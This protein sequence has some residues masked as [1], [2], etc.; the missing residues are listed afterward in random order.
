MTILTKYPKILFV[1]MTRVYQNDAVNLMLRNLFGDWP[2]ENLAQIYTGAYKGTEDFCGYYF[3]IGVKER[4][5]GWLFNI[6][7]PVGMGTLLGYSLD[8]GNQREKVH[9]SRVQRWIANMVSRFVA[10]GYWELV[11]NVH[12]SEELLE[13]LRKFEP[14]I[15]Y[16]QGYSLGLTSLSL[17]IAELFQ[18]PICYFP[19]DD[20]HSSLYSGSRLHHRVE[21]IATRL[22]R[23]ASIRFALGPKMAETLTSRYNVLFECLYHAD[24]PDRFNVPK[25]PKNRDEIIIGYAGSLY[26]GRSSAIQDLLDACVLINYPFKIE[27]YSENIP[28][29]VPPELID[30]PYVSFLPLPDHNLLPTTLANC[31]ILFLPESFEK[32][33]KSAIELSL[34]TKA[35]LYMFSRRPIIVYAPPWSGTVD[36]AKRFGWGI[37]VDQR[38][39]HLLAEGIKMAL[40]S[41]AKELVE[42]AYRN[43]LLNHDI[44]KLRAKVQKKITAVVWGN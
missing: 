10:S 32:K 18:I 26:L 36:Y 37:V 5:L 4:R 14:E 24:S 23:N 13:F 27:V 6:L 30:S 22:A 40:S 29:D 31:D 9:I 19:M 25:S 8:R 34:S 35:H 44:K 38:N 43:A 28:P 3:H 41:Q 7:K 16:T 21:E 17:K 33:Y 12:L 42:T 1:H 39:I 20:W 11:F 15:L 2:K